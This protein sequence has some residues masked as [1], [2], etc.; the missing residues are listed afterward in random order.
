MDAPETF[1]T[2]VAEFFETATAEMAAKV[3]D[4]PRELAGEMALH[5][6]YAF[7]LQVRLA[8]TFARRDEPA[9]LRMVQLVL[10][11]DM[12][13][14]VRFRFEDGADMLHVEPVLDD[15]ANAPRSSLLIK[16]TL[17]PEHFTNIAQSGVQMLIDSFGATY[18][19]NIE[20]VAPLAPGFDEEAVMA[21]ID[22]QVRDRDDNTG[23]ARDDEGCDPDFAAL[24]DAIQNVLRPVATESP[25]TGGD[26]YLVDDDWGNRQQKIEIEKLSLL[27]PDIIHAL[28]RLLD[29]FPRWEI[30]VAAGQPDG[31]P[32]GLTLRRHEIID[33]LLREYLPP[34]F[35]G[36]RYDDA[37]IGTEND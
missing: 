31:P 15:M 27:H 5:F 30:V 35:R 11:G 34:E 33:G 22:A 19:S 14:V 8:R 9:E 36:F 32:M 4:A 7:D 23:E 16:Q 18:G 24:Y 1:R 26:Y 29:R 37:R 20:I 10:K 3:P 2:L 13:R 6:A 28:R 25:Y 21:L 12:D 17:A